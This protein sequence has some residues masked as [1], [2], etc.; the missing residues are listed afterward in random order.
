MS[1]LEGLKETFF[2]EC[3]ERLAELENELSRMS[4]DGP[5]DEGLNAIFRSA[6]SIKAGAAAFKFKDLVE[7]SHEFEAVLDLLRAHTLQVD[8]EMMKLLFAA[9][10]VLAN[11]VEAA[12]YGVDVDEAVVK[13]VQGQLRSM[14]HASGDPNAT[15]DHDAPDNETDDIEA[16][17]EVVYNISFKP[18]P[19]LFKHANDPIFI[20]RE[21]QS[22]G[23]LDVNI[24]V[25]A[26]P[27]LENLNAEAS[28]LSWDLALK[29]EKKRADI[30]EVFEFVIDDCELDIKT[31]EASGTNIEETQNAQ[32]AVAQPEE[33]PSVTKT[34]TPEKTPTKSKPPAKKAAGNNS[35]QHKTK[36][37]RVDLQ[38]IDKLV[39]MVGEIVITQSMLSQMIQQNT[40]DM[41][42]DVLRG[43]E[44][45][46][47]HT[48]ELQESV[49]AV[50]MQPV[51]SLFARMPRV[52]R[53]LSRR[54]DKDIQLI[55]SGEDTEIDKTVIEEVSDPINHLLR[56]AID[57]GVE[58]PDARVASGKPKQGTI[59]LSA[60]HR[61]GSIVISISDDGGGINREKVLARAIERGVV[62]PDDQLS[63]SEIENLI[64]SPGF[65]T[66]GQVTD[67]SGRGVGLDV[68]RRNIENL[69]GRVSVSSKYGVGTTFTLLLPLTLAVL[70]GMIV[71]VGEE[72]YVIPLTSIV[73]SFR[74]NDEEVHML[75]DD[76]KV[77]SIRGQYFS[78]VYLGHVFDVPK[79]IN[80][81]EKGLVILVETDSMGKIGLVVDDIEGQQQVVIKSLEE[82]YDPVPGISAATILGDGKVALI[83]DIDNLRNSS[84]HLKN[85]PHEAVL[86][87]MNS[88]TA[89]TQE[90][91]NSINNSPQQQD[92]TVEEAR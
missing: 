14:L 6:H 57:H 69:G 52:V 7:F 45:L 15:K 86:D 41:N 40:S 65:S 44:D 71:N 66:A 56:N 1:D 4:Q 22:L 43:L 75:P 53:D 89:I 30:D 33:Q 31:S 12:R 50:R 17:I 88:A 54:L 35:A 84:H 38:R 32:E 63:S 28:Y 62:G 49:M 48:R 37:I 21:L 25:S 64:F 74:P 82:N 91:S 79:A 47:L 13:D 3:D 19:E 58:Q 16:N 51:G 23:D 34:N 77:V 24:D 27:D 67:I 39:N 76:R 20:I 61:G 9:S 87:S 5:D 59:K 2:E 80:N 85:R 29:S 83:L 70:D 68:V 46:A 10:D 8:E 60:E 18:K 36:S 73:E 55:M 81:P 90:H 11:L 92:E 42:S 26:L 78:L 72:K